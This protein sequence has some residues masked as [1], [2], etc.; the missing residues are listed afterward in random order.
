MKLGTFCW[1][2]RVDFDGQGCPRSTV[3]IILS[4]LYTVEVETRDLRVEFVL[5]LMAKT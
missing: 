3:R 4:L 1:W 2:I 5:I